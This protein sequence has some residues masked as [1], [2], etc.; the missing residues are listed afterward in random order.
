MSLRMPL[1]DL[2]PRGALV[3]LGRGALLPLRAWRVMREDPRLQ[4][5]ARVCAVVTAVTLVGVVWVVSRYA[6]DALGMLWARP[7]SGWRYAWDLTWFLVWV[8]AVVVGANTVP[9]LLL[10]PLQDPLSEATEAA[11]GQATTSQFTP[12]GL[13]RGVAT[14][15]AHTLQRIALLIVGHTL[16]LALH[17]IPGAGSLTWSVVATIWTAA[18]LAAEYLDVPMARHLYR[19]AQ[20]RAVLRKRLP[21]SLGFGLGLYVLLWIPVV[22]LFLVPIAVVAG[23][24]MFCALR[25]E[26]TLSSPAQGPDRA[27]EGLGVP[28]R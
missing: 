2:R 3:D 13:V 23:T 25:S 14:S 1:P 18:W 6:D 4:R 26:G 22:N 16:L 27:R 19:F 24:L 9:L 15:I 7:A 20:V 10:A 28:R 17:L 5:L 8:G 21:L 12:M 11:C